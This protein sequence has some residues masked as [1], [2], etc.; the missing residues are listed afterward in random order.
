MTKQQMYSAAMNVE[1][2]TGFN[3]AVAPATLMFMAMEAVCP[4]AFLGRTIQIPY[5]LVTIDADGIVKHQMCEV[6]SREAYDSLKPKL[7][8]DVIDWNALKFYAF[9]SVVDS[10]F[11]QKEL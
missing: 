4:S 6:S 2:L 3:G 5:L 1:S 9:V 8:I 10:S 11:H 7:S